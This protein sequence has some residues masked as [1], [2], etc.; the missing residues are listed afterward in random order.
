MSSHKKRRELNRA[1]A[2]H[3]HKRVISTNAVT[4]AI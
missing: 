1:T 4:I 3:T 2:E